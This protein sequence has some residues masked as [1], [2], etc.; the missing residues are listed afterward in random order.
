MTLAI[1]LKYVYNTQ[2]LSGFY[3][4]NAMK[5]SFN[6]YFWF[7]WFSFQTV[8][9]YLMSL[10]ELS[11]TTGLSFPSIYNLITVYDTLSHSGIPRINSFW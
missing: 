6:A 8:T 5:V 10:R 2:L 1:S 9:F 11:N 3:L 7:I 4:N